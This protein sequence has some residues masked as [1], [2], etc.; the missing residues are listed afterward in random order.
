MRLAALL[1]FSDFPPCN[2]G[3]A[4]PR[5]GAGRCRVTLRLVFA[6]LALLLSVVVSPIPAR[7]QQ[8]SQPGFDVRQTEKRFDAIQ[9][10]QTPANRSPLQMPLLSRPRAR[11]DS[12]PLFALRQVSLA[13]ARAISDDQL[14]RT[15][16]PYL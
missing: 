12:K 8:A 10:E 3:C 9:S 11:A 16:E 14:V 6:G 4:A 15:Y 5:A 2:Y 1:A 13:G 7:A